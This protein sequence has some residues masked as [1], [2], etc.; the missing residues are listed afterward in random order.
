MRCPSCKE[1][2]KDKVID[3]RLTEGGAAIRR[4]RECTGCG[5]RFTTKERMEDEIR[6]TVIKRDFSRVPYDRT[7]ILAGIQKAC[8]KRQIPTEALQNIL[9]EIEEIIFRECDRE[10][11]TQFIGSVVG[12]RLRDVDKV[13]YVRFMSVHQKFETIDDFIDQIK[14]IREISASEMP[15]QQ[16]L[17]DQGG[18]GQAT[19]QTGG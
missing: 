17:F 4:R 12:R 16:S 5:R 7:K 13:A 9:N 3:S 11:T 15:G 19:D 2:D 1:I 8:F 18:D 14:N 10:V 6:I